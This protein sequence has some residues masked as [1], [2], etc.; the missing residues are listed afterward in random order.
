MS[1]TVSAEHPEFG[2][3][4]GSWAGTSNV[5]RLVL[6]RGLLLTATGNRYWDRPGTASTRRWATFLFQV[7]PRDPLAS[8]PHLGDDP[9]IGCSLFLAAWRA[10]RTDPHASATRG[11][12]F[13]MKT[14]LYFLPSY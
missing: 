2:A 5:L 11:L 9:C 6:L 10:T 3:A 8:P 14:V 1:Y 13:H 7:S 4:Y 12:I